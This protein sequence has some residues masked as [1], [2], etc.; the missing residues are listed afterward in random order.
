MG[1]DL[2][3]A[4]AQ[5]VPVLALALVVEV[6]TFARQ[7]RNKRVFMKSRR[8]RTFFALSSLASGI[9]LLATLSLAL[10]AL[11]TETPFSPTIRMLAIL[12][13]SFT[14]G[15]IVGNPL[16]VLLAAMTSDVRSDHRYRVIRRGHQHD[17]DDARRFISD[18]ERRLR[19]RW[20]EEMTDFTRNYTRAMAVARELMGNTDHESAEQQATAF[21]YIADLDAWLVE[22]NARRAESKRLLTEGHELVRRYTE[23]DPFDVKP[24][25]ASLR[26]LID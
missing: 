3:A 25:L 2:W 4:I 17:L 9:L 6:R 18:S 20:L 8:Q 23:V 5:L 22:A 12:A 26:L 13:L 24:H 21:R 7:V 16:V 10:A 14:F 19:A 11:S 15:A 1:L